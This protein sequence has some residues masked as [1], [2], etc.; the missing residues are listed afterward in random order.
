MMLKDAYKLKIEAEME[1]AQAKLLEF[2]AEAK[3]YTADAYIKYSKHLEE[4]DNMHRITKDKLLEL[5]NASEDTWEKVK[6]GAE[7]AWNSFSAAVKDTANKFRDTNQ[8]T[9]K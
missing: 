2:K 8:G 7:H 4:L 9:T 1:L 3:N 5:E 6:D